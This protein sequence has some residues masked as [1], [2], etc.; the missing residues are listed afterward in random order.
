VNPAEFANIAR[1]EQT[2][3]WFRGMNRI[4]FALLRRYSAGM[5]IRSVL[6][7]GCGTGYLSSLLQRGFGWRMTALDLSAEGLRYARG[8]GVQSATQGDLR[9]LP[10]A[11]NSFDAVLSMD[12]LVHFPHGEE[13]APIGELVRV[14]R[15]RGLLVLRVSALDILRSRHSIFAHERQRFTRP[16]LL[17]AMQSAGIEVLRCTYANSLLMP[18]AIAKF[19]IWEPF[20]NQ[21][22]ASGVQRAHPI[23]DRLLGW[24]LEIEAR[25]LGAGFN[26]PAGQSLLLVGRK[27]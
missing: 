3:W 6:E 22:P 1:A 4:L 23:L 18:V 19:R 15:P 17:R 27:P 20:T 8:L 26:F 21:P 10:F 5:E 14:L 16:R 9:H 25:W 2:M 13:P 24:P 7:G 12:V 11:D